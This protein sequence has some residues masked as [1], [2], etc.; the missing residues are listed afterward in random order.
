MI[1]KIIASSLLSMLMLFT[2]L[3]HAD[4]VNPKVKESITALM[5]ETA[6]LGTPKAESGV[7]YFG[8]AKINDDFTVVDAIKTR[9][10]G[11]ATLFVKKDNSF[12]R[13][14]T[15]VM[16]NGNR[17]IGTQLDP[18][19][20]AMAA[21]REGKTYYGIVDILGKLFDTAYA[22]IKDATGSIVG[23]YYVGYLIE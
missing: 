13:I 12:V 21:I 5:A 17:A 19:G 4:D 8:T 14:S 7:L 23:I 6:K 1:K 10:G 22:P 2:L 18:T 16:K 9:F 15:N 11:T 3:S 20:P